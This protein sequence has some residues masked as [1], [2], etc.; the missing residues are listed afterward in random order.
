MRADKGKIIV[1]LLLMFSLAGC[2]KEGDR[3]APPPIYGYEVISAYPHDPEAFTQGLTLYE[4]RLYEGTGLKG[5]SSLREVD[6][7]TGK[8][9]RSYQL[10][11]QLF[12]EGITLH[13]NKIIQIT[14]LSKLGFIFD[15]DTFQLIG[16]FQ[17]PT[18]GWGLT[19]DN[20][21]IIMSDG[22]AVIYFLDPQTFTQVRRITV[23]DSGKPVKF[24]NELEYINGSLYANI[25]GE[26]RIAIINPEDGQVTA[27]IVLDGLACGGPNYT[28]NGIAY[29]AQTGNLL[30][31]GKLCPYLY[32]IKLKP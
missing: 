20:R 27:W 29:D 17:Y 32:E 19:S 16:S 11:P 4:G 18:E 28:L 23:T 10:D 2:A 22:T 30:V 24:I 26:K 25:L 6:L 1:A 8:T 7:R 21:N 14:W 3:R 31:T 9:I 13:G 5:R 12:G 15:K